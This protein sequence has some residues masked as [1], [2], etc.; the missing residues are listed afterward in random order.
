MDT[1]FPG[2]PKYPY[3]SFRIKE[4]DYINFSDYFIVSND[5]IITSYDKIIIILM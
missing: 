4:N 5:M 2:Q 3:Q 1:S